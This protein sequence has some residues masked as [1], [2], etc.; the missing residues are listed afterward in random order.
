MFNR[1]KNNITCNVGVIAGEYEAIKDLLLLNYLVSQ[2]GNT[3]HY[4]DQSSFNFIVNSK[5]AEGVVQIEGLETNWAYQ[6]GTMNNPHLI[7]QKKYS[8]EEYVIVH[9]Y[10]RVKEY[11]DFITKKFNRQ[12]VPEPPRNSNPVGFSYREWEKLRKYG[13]FDKSY[14]KFLKDKRV[15]VVGPSP[16]LEGSSK[17]KEIDSYDIVVRV[18][19][20]FPIEK[21]LETDI[22]SRTDIHYHCLCEEMHCGGPVFYK[23]MKEE[24]V[25]VS[26]PYPK[27]VYPFT[28][29]VKRFEQNNKQWDLDFHV[30]D[31]DY[32]LGIANMI[33]T[34]ANSGILTILDLLCYD[35]KELHV[36]GFTFFRDGW[37][38][39][40]KDHTKIFGEEEGKKKEE[41]WL[42]GE[43]EGNHLQK[44]Q[45]DLV[46]EIYLNDNRVTIDKVM[47]EILEVK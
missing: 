32:Y 3:Q 46:R 5:L 41:Q 2:A 47:K 44:P 39:S 18:N 34:R 9:Q 21:G 11:N 10:D 29:D 15:I 7:G 1:Y 28:I 45:E 43:F 16:S 20:A 37:R 40:Y 13:Q 38:K 22:G 33:G 30:I 42:K 23:E 25:F 26:C 27:Y 19:K 35:I 17:G 31:T 4:T 36:T 24:N 6:I 14:N 8:I 12:V